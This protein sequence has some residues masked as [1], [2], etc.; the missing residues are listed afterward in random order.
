MLDK[1]KKRLGE[2][3]IIAVTVALSILF[4]NNW[5]IPKTVV[6]TYTATGEPAANIEVE[7]N[8]PYSFLA[9]KY[10]PLGASLHDVKPDITSMELNKAIIY[11]MEVKSLSTASAR[12]HILEVCGTY[13]FHN[14]ESQTSGKTSAPLLPQP[15]RG[16]ICL[17]IIRAH[18]S[19]CPEGTRLGE[20]NVHNRRC[21][22]RRETYL[23][24]EAVPT[25]SPP[26]GRHLSSF[27][28]P[29]A[30]SAVKN[31]LNI[32]STMCVFAESPI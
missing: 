21:V 18:L 7:I 1:R 6:I 16:N 9:G 32:P 17:Q 14:P 11:P 20:A 29:S 25:Y 30:Q 8:C 5:F 4:Y 13:N 24:T 2:V 28:A 12:M 26:G 3:I 23:R 19:S 27:S 22:S 15:R 31:F 10:D